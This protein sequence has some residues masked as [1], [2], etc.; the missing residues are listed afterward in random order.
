[1]QKSARKMGS[2]LMFLVGDT[3]NTV[4]AL[5]LSQHLPSGFVLNDGG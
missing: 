5:C 4:V 3:A 1:M 2:A